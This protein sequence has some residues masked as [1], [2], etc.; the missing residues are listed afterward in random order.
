MGALR[1]FIRDHRRT[2]LAVGLLVFAL[3]A[4][5]PPGYMVGQHAKV[6]T[7]EIC[8]D[9]IDAHLSRQIVVPQS[10]AAGKTVQEHGKTA[11]ICPYA[12]LSMPSL[13]GADAALLALALT[14]I[15]ALGF[16]SVRP[17]R[18]RREL[19]LRPPLRG[20][21]LVGCLTE[22]ARRGQG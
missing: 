5:V 20:P 21:P 17:A 19:H 13:A 12:A 18:P 2:A 11:G 9:T 15:F 3:K 6:L 10:G 4:L 14:F 22:P 7:I 8:A 1:N 16:A